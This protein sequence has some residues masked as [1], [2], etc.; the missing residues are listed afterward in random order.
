MI[1]AR[2]SHLFA[3]AVR[4]RSPRSYAAATAVTTAAAFPARLRS[5]LDERADAQRVQLARLLEALQRAAGVGDDANLSEAI[6]A[7][8]DDD[9][10]SIDVASLT[11]GA[12]TDAVHRLCT[13]SSARLHPSSLQ[14]VLNAAAAVAEQ[15][16]SVVDLSSRA[17]VS[18]V[19][20]LHG[21]ASSLHRVLQLTGPPSPAAAIVFNGDF[22]D[23]G[24]SGVEVLAAVALLK[25]CHPEDVVL[26]RGNHEDELLATAY[27]FRDELT[28]KYPEHAAE[29]WAA[30]VGLFA[31]LPLAAT[32][33]EA[34]IV[35]GGLPSDQFE[36]ADLAALSAADRAVPSVLPAGGGGEERRQ[37]MAGVL[38]SDPAHGRGHVGVTSNEARGGTGV[39]FAEDVT[40]D[41][42]RRHSMRLLI[43]SHQC[44]EE[45][46]ERTD[47]GGDAEMYTVFSAALYPNGEGANKGAVLKL[48]RTEGAASATV[49]P[50]TF[51][52]SVTATAGREAE[53]DVR[54]SLGVLIRSHRGRLKERFAA[55]AAA[56]AASAQHATGRAAAAASRLAASR[57]SVGDWAEVMR[58]E[59][60]LHVD[61]EALQP[62]L[63]PTVKRGGATGLVD[64][65]LLDFERFLSSRLVAGDDAGKETAAGDTSTARVARPSG[66]AA[67]SE[68]DRVYRSLDSLH[69]VV[70]ML[71]TD[72]NGVI[73]RE[74]F[75][76]GFRLLNEQL[77]EGEK[78]AGDPDALF[79]AM[80]TDGSGE[81][82]MAELT[83]AFRLTVVR[84]GG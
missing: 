44:V 24:E 19:G 40:R 30:A 51:G 34:F 82:S 52:G 25:A 79:D 43:R 2:P 45:G 26:L 54:R 73:D 18:V 58:D 69:A 72:R 37:L 11:H 59:L 46:V 66:G 10:L 67:A 49:E 41:F 1:R 63:A 36:I 27:G 3:R 39:I 13:D 14:Q 16:S 17:C 38:W 20:D 77:A 65:G 84:G 50:I 7:T 71:D 53:A 68:V 83:E 78:L 5:A 60:K 75:R 32:A 28:R 22:V 80:D 57:I 64:T 61:W 4:G 74:E 12:I 15:E 62:A 70:Q 8:P 31:S 76:E 42:L 23:R 21:C 6:A 55:A 35:H 29:L 47:L 9:L 48:R 56:Q 81:V 33:P